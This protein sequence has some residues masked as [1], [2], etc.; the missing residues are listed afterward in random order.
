MSEAAEEVKPNG[1][2]GQVFEGPSD[3]RKE[4]P[5]KKRGRPPK[6]SLNEESIGDEKPRKKP[7]PKPGSKRKK[8]RTWD[9]E[10]RQALARQLIGIHMLAVSATGLAELAISENEAVLLADAMANVAQEYDLALDGKT[11]ATIQLIATGAMIY[12]PRIAMIN[13]RME[14]QKHSEPIDGEYESAENPKS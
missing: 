11:G 5:R 7:G 14:K 3:E 4:E 1:G 12:L 8:S 10:A 2:I 9:N 6:D 13:Q